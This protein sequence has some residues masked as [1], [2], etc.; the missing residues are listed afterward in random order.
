MARAGAEADVIVVGAG[1]AGLACARRLSGRGLDVRCYD[2]SDAVGGRVRTDVV[3]GF[4]LDRG[5]QVLNTGYPEVVRTVDL[6][7][8]DLREFDAAVRIRR[9]GVIRRVP[10]PLAAH[11]EWGALVRARPTSVSGSLA[12][13]AY[14]TRT[15]A[16][17]TERVLRR[18]DVAGPEAWRRSG[19]SPRTI[20]ELLTPFLGGVVLER[21]ITTSRHFLD[22]MVRMFARGRSAVPSRGMQRLPEQLA[23]QLP[24]GVL[25][26]EAPVERVR[27]DR[28][29]VGGTDVG[30]RAVVVAVDPWSARDLVPELGPAPAARGVT[31]YYYAA[32]P[33]VDQTSTL[34]LDADGS[35]LANSVV[36]TAAAPEY[37]G[38]G[39]SLISA[40]VVHAGPD[41]PSER[42]VRGTLAALYQRDTRDWELVARYDVARALPA[43]TAPH[44]MRRPVALAGG[45]FVAGDHRDTSSIQGALVSGRRAADAVLARLGQAP[46]RST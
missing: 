46:S 13:G 34:V 23:A 1:L 15:L 26:L 12:V 31:T 20:D 4:R 29:L 10:N 45:L 5:F 17:P 30:A 18:P 24:D 14:L 8:L 37:S 9:G 39:R 25:R 38:D 40:S 11:G 42:S 27:A 22:L 44:P 16:L 7:A 3:D 35:G 21:E 19:I 2:A 43:M 33:W 28:V 32:E 41:D 36:L 6:A